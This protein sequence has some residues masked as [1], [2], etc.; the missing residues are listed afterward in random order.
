MTSHAAKRV[1]AKARDT[2]AVIVE[3]GVLA[4]VAA[5]RAAH[6][7]NPRVLLVVDEN[8]YRAVGR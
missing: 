3:P 5:I 4:A 2:R 8:S 7:A 1:P 6:F